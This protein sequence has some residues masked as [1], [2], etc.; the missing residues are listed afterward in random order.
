VVL[1]ALDLEAMAVVGAS[2]SVAS[3]ISASPEASPPSA[4]RA[5]ASGTGQLSPRTSNSRS[6]E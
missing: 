4:A 3:T 6:I 2:G 5:L 1:L